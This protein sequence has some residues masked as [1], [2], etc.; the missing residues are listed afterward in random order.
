MHCYGLPQGRCGW[1]VSMMATRFVDE[2]DRRPSSRDGKSVRCHCNGASFFMPS[3]SD[4]EQTLRVLISPPDVLHTEIHVQTTTSRTTRVLELCQRGDEG[5]SVL[6][7]DDEGELQAG[8]RLTTPHAVLDGRT[9]LM[10][11]QRLWATAPT[12][13][14]D[15]VMAIEL[16]SSFRP[17]QRS[18]PAL[19]VQAWRFG[20]GQQGAMLLVSH[21]GVNTVSVPLPQTLPAALNALII[22]LQSLAN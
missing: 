1:H 2:P 3:I 4:V 6:E 12:D 14:S 19:P 21:D 22:H 8:L 5:V 16:T 18:H 11:M 9:V 15:E 17:T 20:V 7:W 10:A 13:P